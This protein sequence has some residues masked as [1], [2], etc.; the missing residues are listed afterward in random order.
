MK[1]EEDIGMCSCPAEARRR[2]RVEETMLR[3]REGLP[4]W[5]PM[6]GRRDS[7]QAPLQH[8]LHIDMISNNDLFFMDAAKT[9]LKALGEFRGHTSVPPDNL[10]CSL[11][12]K[13]LN[14]VH[15]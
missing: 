15:I 12:F 11:K 14:S 13:L 7:P 9:L 2:R 1:R 10:L 8:C 3:V 6:A 5:V 4:L